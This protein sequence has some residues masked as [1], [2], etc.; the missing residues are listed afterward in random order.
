MTIHVWGRVGPGGTIAENV[1][2]DNTLSGATA[3][4]VQDALDDIYSG[5]GVAIETT[6]DMTLYVR[7]TGSDS[8]DGRTVGNALATIQRAVDLIPKF[9]RHQVVIDVG[10]GNFAGAYASAFLEDSDTASGAFTVRGVLGQPTLTTGT[11]TGTATGGSTIQLVDS[12][13]S[14]TTNELRGELLKVGSEYR[15]IYQND[16]TTIDVCEPFGSSVSGKA[17]EI[18]TQKTVV[19]VAESLTGYGGFSGRGN[20]IQILVQ[21]I[22]FSSMLIGI[23]S[24]YSTA[25]V[26]ATR[27]KFDSNTYAGYFSQD[28]FQEFE[29]QQCSAMSCNK[30]YFITQGFQLRAL[31]GCL[32]YNSTST[33]FDLYSSGEGY[34][35]LYDL[36]SIDNGAAGLDLN[37]IFANVYLDNGRFT[38]N[39]GYGIRVLDRSQLNGQWRD[40]SLVVSNN[41]SGG[42]R[43]EGGSRVEMATVTGSGNGGYGVSLD[44]GARVEV[45][46]ATAVTGS[47]GDAT[48]D[49]STEL[50]WATDFASDGDIVTNPYNGC[51]LVRDD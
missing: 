8:N 10:E 17:Y 48:V 36:V 21:D 13:Q 49:G 19:N 33:G 25:P 6:A 16:G 37:Q 15:V 47:S 38:G 50:A 24:F 22:K 18:L 9:I 32:A 42:I 11:P 1:V 28:S 2:Y 29:I 14:W 34:I 20:S 51:R 27:C 3:E 45:T 4:T 30:G 40:G 26:E 46:S 39:A 12:G 43:V 23:G 35:N 44:Q 41:T 5:I 31:R 7:S